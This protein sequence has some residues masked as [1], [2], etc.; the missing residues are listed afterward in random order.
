MTQ[1][2]T[3]KFKVVVCDL[4]GT[5]LPKTKEISKNTLDYLITLQEKGIYVIVATGRNPKET[6]EISRNLRCVDYHGFLV[7]CNG[8]L[9]HSFEKGEDIEAKRVPREDALRLAKLGKKYHVMISVDNDEALY[10]SKSASGLFHLIARF[11]KQIR[12][13]RWVFNQLKSRNIHRLNHIED[14]INKDLRKICFSGS[15]SSLLRLSQE[16]NQQFPDRFACMFVA[17]TW[18]EIMESSVSK[19]HA[20]ETIS[21]L[22]DVPLEQFIAFGDGE[23]DI[24]M[25]QKAGWGVAMANAMPSVKAV[26]DD[27]AGSNDDEGVMNYLRQLNQ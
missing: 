3:T 10:Q 19:G 6:F 22:I 11:S 15:P 16:V 4:D 5:L 2:P 7:C 12:N 1:K 14:A 24:T 18:L 20:L 26:A 13:T 21:K 23:N 27:I 17:E 8:Q 25:L 9:I